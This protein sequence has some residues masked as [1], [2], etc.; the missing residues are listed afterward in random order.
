VFDRT[1]NL[2]GALSLVITDHTGDAIQEAAGVSGSQAAALS[3]MYHFLD[4]PSVDQLR[5][6]LGLSPSGTV[7]LVDR[8][9][10]DGYLARG[11]GEDGRTRRVSLTPLGREAAA[12]VAEARADTLSRSLSNLDPRERQRLDAILGEILA[13]M[14]RPSGATRWICRL[15][16][17]VTC[18]RHDGLCPVANAALRDVDLE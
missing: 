13:G 15:C 6:V 1:G 14:V 4:S 5:Q 18:G 7:R 17:T 2:L 3:A 12:K 9:E 16:D 10:A 8:L 11:P